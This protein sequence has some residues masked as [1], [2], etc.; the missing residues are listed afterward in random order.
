[1]VRASSSVVPVSRPFDTL[2]FKKTEAPKGVKIGYTATTVLSEAQLANKALIASQ[3]A[4]VP[5]MVEVLRHESTYRQFNGSG[6][7]LI[8][9]TGDVGVGQI[10]IATW[11]EIAKKMGLDIYNSVTDNLKMTRYVYEVQGLTA[12]TAYKNML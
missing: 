5:I 11:G 9:E 10:N 12:W 3:F 8:S 6:N 1:M 2:N 7:P 4:D